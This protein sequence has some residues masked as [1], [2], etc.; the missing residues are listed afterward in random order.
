MNKIHSI[1]SMSTVIVI[2]GLCTSAVAQISRTE[3]GRLD[4]FDVKAMVRNFGK[5]MPERNLS[6]DDILNEI[7]TP[8]LYFTAQ[9]DQTFLFQKLRKGEMV[10]TYGNYFTDFPVDDHALVFYINK[11]RLTRSLYHFK[12]KDKHM[13]VIEIDFTNVIATVS[14]GKY[15]INGEK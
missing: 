6:A 8:D 1:I 13:F 10:I 2:F 4:A 11:D 9:H 5:R 14:Q 12:P 15:N 7:G 3:K